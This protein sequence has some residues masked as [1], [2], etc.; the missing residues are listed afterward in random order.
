VDAEA[1]TPSARALHRLEASEATMSELDSHVLSVVKTFDT[2]IL[3]TR[4][5]EGILRGR[6]MT[7]ADIDEHGSIYLVTSLDSSKATDLTGDSRVA[8]GMQSDTAYA[9]ISGV[10]ILSTDRTIIDRLWR[11]EWRAWF[12]YGKDSPDLCVVEVHPVAGECWSEELGTGEQ[13]RGQA[14]GNR[15]RGIRDPH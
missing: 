8:L 11:D 1:L 14:T 9:S 6:P 4:T 2:A 10:A 3:F 12:P 7:I 15:E 13:N 5:G